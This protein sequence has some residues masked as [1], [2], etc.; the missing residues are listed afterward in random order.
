MTTRIVM[1]P[2]LGADARLFGPQLDRFAEA[3]VPGWIPPVRGESIGAYAVRFC[4]S[5]IEPAPG[6]DWVAVGFSFGGMVALELASRLPEDRRPR[7]VGLIS[8]IRSHRSVG[9]PFRVASAV[10]GAVPGW[11]AR[12]VLAGPGSGLF[13]RALGLERRWSDELHAMAS[14]LDWD[15][16]RW[17]SG[18]CRRWGFDGRCPVPVSWIHGLRDAV[19]PYVEHGGFDDDLTLLDDSSHLLTWTRQDEVA[20]WLTGLVG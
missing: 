12:P 15:F 16:L 6:E 9:T 7:A 1:L 14:D 2:G 10:G 17:G 11:L 19:V 20:A 3:T 4:E 13:A 5:A 18:A 8:G